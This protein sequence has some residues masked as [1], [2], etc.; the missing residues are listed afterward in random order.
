[1]IEVNESLDK[2]KKEYIV[3]EDKYNLPRFDELNREFQIE[4]LVGIETDYLIR[5]ISKMVSEKLSD[6][7]KFIEG[8]LHPV[9]GSILVFSILRTIGDKERGMLAD[10]YKDIAKVE[11]K[12]IRMGLEFNEEKEVAFIKEG[13]IL[14]NKVKEK[15]SQVL[16]AVEANWEKDFKINGQNGYFS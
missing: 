14:W 9:N 7:L 11:L 5:E 16:D 15:L 8:I 4:K 12:M 13:I 6:F 1:M 10:I 2:L 3:L